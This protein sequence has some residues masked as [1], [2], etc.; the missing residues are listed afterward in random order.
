MIE[1]DDARFPNR[2]IAVEMIRLISH[3]SYV[4]YGYLWELCVSFDNKYNMSREVEV[5]R[6]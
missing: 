6:K 5:E 2:A 4:A 3:V 1:E